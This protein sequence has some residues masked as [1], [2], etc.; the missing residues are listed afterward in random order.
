MKNKFGTLQKEKQNNK[1]LKLSQNISA[2]YRTA[3]PCDV[4][5]GIRSYCT[6]FD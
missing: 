4:C 1:V 2:K 3:M 5:F 6:I